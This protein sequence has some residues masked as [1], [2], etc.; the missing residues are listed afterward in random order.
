MKTIEKKRPSLTRIFLTSVAVVLF[1][2]A[3][4]KLISAFGSAKI[5]QVP[6]PVFSLPYGELLLWAACLEFAILGTLL[7]AGRERA[8]LCLVGW[9]AGIF[10]LYRGA[11]WLMVGG[12]PCP[13]LGTVTDYLQIPKGVADALLFSFLAYMV[14]GYFLCTWLLSLKDRPVLK[15]AA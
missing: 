5:L 3:S 10:L 4:A 8:K 1:I 15:L 11:N 13:C 14:F 12:A 7:S 9:A 6:D 2:T